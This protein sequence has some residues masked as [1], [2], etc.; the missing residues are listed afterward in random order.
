MSGL[1]E[2][3]HLDNGDTV[4]DFGLTWFR[5]RSDGEV[6]KK[7]AAPSGVRVKPATVREARKI[8][9]LIQQHSASRPLNRKS[10]QVEA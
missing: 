5:V 7:I 2:I 3:R 6:T 9:A 1:P 4:V 8:L 10:E